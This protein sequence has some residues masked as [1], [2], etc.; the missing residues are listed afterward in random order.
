MIQT[1]RTIVIVLSV[2][3]AFELATHLIV[4]VL[5]FEEVGYLTPF[6]QRLLWQ[7]GLW[8]VTSSLSLGFLLGNLQLAGHLRWKV[9]PEESKSKAEDKENLLLP[10]LSIKLPLLLTLVLVFDGL[11]GLMLVHYSQ[12]ALQVWTPD[13]NLPTIAPPLPS[14]FEIE[15]VPQLLPAFSK[16]WWQVVAIALTLVFLLIKRDLCLRAIAFLFSLLFGLVVSGNWTRVVLAAHAT[17]F[18]QTDPQFGNDIGF[19]IFHLPLW[20]LLDFW[21]GGL[22]LYG[23]IA[24]TLT[25]LLSG[26]SVSQGKFP[27]F[28]RSQLRH[29]YGLGGLMM[30]IVGLRHWLARYALLYSPRGV[31]YGAGFTDVH[32]QLPVE[33]VLAGLSVG[34]ALWLLVK[35]I[36]D[37][38]KK[39]VRPTSR[40]S[41]PLSLFPFYAYLVILAVG[42]IGNVTV[43][44]LVVQPNE[45]ARERPYIERSIRL[46]RAAFDL[47]RVEVKT[48]APQGQ[49]TL[50]DLQKNDLTIKNIRLWD[51][52]P[53]LQTNRQLQQIRL[54]YK[55]A[56]ADIDRYAIKVKQG[57]GAWRSEKQQVI[58]AA[59]ELDYAAVPDQAKTWVNEHLVYTHG[60]G[61]TLS[62]VNLATRGGLPFYFVQ[63]IGTE[64]E[65]G[66]LRI[67]DELIRASIPTS[68]PR[69]YYGE[70]TNPYIM[71]HTKVKELDFPSGQENAYNTYDGTGGIQIGSGWL[72]LVFAQYLKDW[73]MLFTENFT[74]QTRLLFRR[75]FNYR[76]REIAPFLY[77]DRDPYLVVADTGRVRANS[78]P[79]YLYWIVDAYTT[80]DRYPYSDPGSHQFN[81]IRNSVKIVVDA[82]NGDVTFYIADPSDPLIQS[83]R[84]AFPQLFKPL[85]AMP[86]SLRS[87][88]RYP[89]DLYS[90]QSERLLTYHMSD[91]Q[92]FYN[93]EDQWRIPQEI[94][95]TKSQLVQPY[96][97]I[98][99]LPTVTAEEFMLLHPYTPKGRN[100]LIAV[101]FGRSDGEEYGKLL[102]YQLPKQE[103]IYGPEQIEALINQDPIISQQISLWNREGSR[104]LQGN[105]LA[106]PIERSLLYV[107]PLYLEA[108]QNSLPTLARVVVVYNNRIVM[109]S[110]LQQA[111]QSLFEAETPARSAI[112]R[113]LE[114]PG[115]NSTFSEPLN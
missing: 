91:P 54:Y 82:Y 69:I 61:F 113:P 11:I 51:T 22:F 17:P 115:E 73:Q 25:Y 78:T 99:K 81:Y 63:D 102:L 58:I 108:E 93:R 75:N 94:Y 5:W 45:L 12:L 40:P 101:L 19:Y 60:Y 52:R 77:Y 47:E 97:L 13:F 3:L 62:P 39:R 88:I 66:A 35:A 59:R 114:E 107:E 57:Q 92:V 87:H 10:S 79:N 70:L 103:L 96:Y 32:V 9:F 49:L 56:N 15:T 23:A 20:K 55:F 67:S 29:L 14:P 111:L 43:Q 31:V 27:G 28:S 41:L 106:I 98:M 46:T 44:R 95:G 21:L 71:T 50:A 18:E 64:K 36:G 112:V 85:E 104:V 72:R 48:F 1:F 30:L 105:L 86:A 84:K 42:A 90:T 26:D 2:W 65:A 37:R 109:A 110:T 74:P 33:S 24:V 76:I 89:E 80:S 53:L 6:L 16:R 7:I 38:P 8:G 100:N 4:E 34:I 68:N 83:W